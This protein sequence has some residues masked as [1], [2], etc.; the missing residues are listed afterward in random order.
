MAELDVIAGQARAEGLVARFGRKLLEV[1]PPVD[2][3]KGT[4]VK[5]LLD[6]AGLTRA[7]VAGDDTTDLDSFRA[8]EGLELRVRVAVASAESPSLL[9]E[10][11]DIVVE[12]TGAFLELLRKL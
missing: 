11:A 9:R 2:A 3:N 7:L 4:A 1:L 12:S 8:V 5:Q 6:E 10:H